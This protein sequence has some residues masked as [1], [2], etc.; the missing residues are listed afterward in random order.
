M[1]DNNVIALINGAKPPR[2]PNKK[3]SG[4]NGGN[5]SGSGG[6]GNTSALIF[7][8]YCIKNGA[9]FHNKPA[10]SGNDDGCISIQLCDFTCRIIEEVTQDSGLEDSTL[11]RIEA[12]RADGYKLPVVDVAANKF[13]SST[14][15][16]ANEAYGTKVF[17]YPGSQKKDHLRA[18]IQRYSTMEADICSRHVYKYTG[19][20]LINAQWHYLTGSGAINASGLQE[21]VNVDMGAGHISRYR[22]PPPLDAEGIRTA[23][24]AV[25]DLL[26]VCQNK[27]HIGAALL[28]AIGRAPL[29]EC[30]PID[31]CL[32]LHGLTGSKKSS[33]V[34][35]ALSFFGEFE[36]N[37]FPSNW[38]DTPNDIE[39]KSF[40]AKDALY[41]V[42]DFKP[43]VSQA[44]AARLHAT[45]ERIIR[46]TGNHAGR[47]R[48]NNDMSS[49]AAPYNRSLTIITGEDLPKGQS[50][51]GRLLIL[52]LTKHDVDCVTLSRLQQA[53]RDRELSGLMAAYIHWLAG[54]MDSF[55][56]TLPQTITAL[57]DEAIN[58]GFAASHPRAPQLFASLVVGANVFIDFLMSSGA[59]SSVEAVVLADTIETELKQA[60]SEQGSYQAEQDEC[61]RFLSLLRSLFN[62]GSAHI[63]DRLNQA[64]PKTRPHNWGWSCIEVDGIETS[65]TML[66]KPKGNQ[67]GWYEDKERQIWLTQE[68]V[69]AEVQQLAR[70]QG[71]PFIMSAP[72]LWRR[73]G[74]RGLITKYETR[75]NG[76]KQWT[77]KRTIG[78]SLKRVM[79]L[80]ADLVEGVNQ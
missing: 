73:M 37:V 76:S 5:G 39:A 66:E 9:F 50:L 16:W 61:E 28:A 45:A 26:S 14:G 34:S 20:K 79:I 42:D 11:L 8:E 13:Y 52:E 70:T 77:V 63:A 4:G 58:A 19:W 62:S 69:F 3:G 68:S 47:G 78:G 38:S 80:S 31:Y 27:K 33:I 23:A 55:K 30:S 71:D 72:T 21:S 44:K 53:A 15:N 32:F 18:A 51:L 43:S 65:H 74:D 36:N 75:E 35:V 48:R 22:L 17:I 67:I 1:V 24:R 6:K 25:Y 7:G 60:F 64:A 2:K 12:T 56:K 54:R 46:N 41:C 29:G 40:Q 49:K 10:R 57:R 59:L